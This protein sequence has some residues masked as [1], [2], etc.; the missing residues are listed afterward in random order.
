MLGQHFYFLKSIKRKEGFT[1]GLKMRNQP[2]HV[3]GGE[4]A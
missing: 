1:E 2:L 3:R 4:N